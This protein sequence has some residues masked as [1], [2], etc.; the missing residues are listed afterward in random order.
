MYSSPMLIYI[1]QISLCS[2]KLALVLSTLVSPTRTRVQPVRQYRDK[3]AINPAQW[4]SAQVVASTGGRLHRVGNR[5]G[6]ELALI[7]S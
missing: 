2:D 7:P 5:C 1:V 3:G 4:P 6:A